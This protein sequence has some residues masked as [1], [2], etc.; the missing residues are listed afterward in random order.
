MYSCFMAYVGR[1]TK[2]EKANERTKIDMDQ[3]RKEF[4]ILLLEGTLSLSSVSASE[5]VNSSISDHI[6][7]VKQLRQAKKPATTVPQTTEENE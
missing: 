5:L 2:Y 7:G 1:N 3:C 4:G 6:E